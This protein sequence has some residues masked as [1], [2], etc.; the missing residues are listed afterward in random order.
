MEA[1]ANKTSNRRRAGKPAAQAAGST[2]WAQK[3]GDNE[4]FCR[5]L[6]HVWASLRADENQRK[7][8]FLQ[9]LLCG[10]CMTLRTRMISSVSGEILSTH[11]TY[12]PTY[13][14]P[15]G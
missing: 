3:L 1:A 15:H 11:Y 7:R 9:T 13:L 6:G 10:R 5:D 2:V 14:V 12:Q 4:L 8:I